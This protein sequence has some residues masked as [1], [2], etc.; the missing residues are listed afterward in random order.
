MPSFYPKDSL[1]DDR[2]LKV[3]RLV[4]PFSIVG[5][6]T[7]ANVSISCDEP[8]IL[9][10]RTEGNDQITTASGALSSGE[11]A[12]YS[13]SPSDSSGIFNVLVK[14]NGEPVQKVCEASL[15]RR[16][17]GTPQ[18]VKLGDADGLSS[19]GKIML[20]VDC[21]LA[22]NSGSNTLDAALCVAYVVQE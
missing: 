22:L 12:T 3:Q 8:S 5:S 14:I 13:V 15:W 21:D 20:T 19:L 18:V 4:I 1:V 7:A 6:A 16:D 10:I 11:T 2:Q 9:F 17:T